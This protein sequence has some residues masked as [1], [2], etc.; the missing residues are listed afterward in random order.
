VCGRLSVLP[1]KGW[2]VH[3][4]LGE[5]KQEDNGEYYFPCSFTYCSLHIRSF[6]W[7]KLKEISFFR[8]ASLIQVTINEHN[9]FRKLHRKRLCRELKRNWRNN[10]YIED[11]GL[12]IFLI[13]RSVTV[14]ERSNA[15]AVFA[16]SEAVIVS[17]NPTQ[18]MNVWCVYVIILCHVY[19]PAFR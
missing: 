7:F 16:R 12:K 6:E 18:G 11:K 5:L 1:A 10:I 19:C 14:A 8:Q 17:S 15:C 4:E 3:L 9:M 13:S 2:S